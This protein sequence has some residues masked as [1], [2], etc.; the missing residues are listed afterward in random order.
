MTSAFGGLVPQVT[1]LLSLSGR[2]F[3]E[4]GQFDDPNATCTNIC[5]LISRQ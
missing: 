3:K 1:W 4:P 5:I 2:R